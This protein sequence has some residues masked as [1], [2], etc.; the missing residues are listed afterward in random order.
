[1]SS[2]LPSCQNLQAN[3]ETLLELLNQQVSLRGYDTT[4]IQASLRKAISPSFEVVFAGAF[5]AGKSMLINA[6]LERELLY[7]A[8]GHATGTECYITYA[9][10]GNEQVVLTFLSEQEIQEQAKAL[11]NRLGIETTA[12]TRPEVMEMLTHKCQE[13]IDREGGKDKSER[14][15]DANALKLL[16]E[17]FQANKER[18]HPT[19][20]R[21][22]S[23]QQFNITNLEEAARYARRGNNSAVL[24]KIHYYCNH[25]LLQ[26]GN[27]L[28]DTPGIDAPVEKDAELTF[29]KVQHPDTS[30]VVCVMKTASA[31]DPTKEETRLMQLTRDNPGVRDRLFYVFNRVDE[32]WYNAQL[33]QRLEQFINNDFRN[34]DRSRL[35]KASGLLGFYG[36]Q[37]QNTSLETRFGL[38]TVFAE[39]I[40]GLGGQEE[41]PQFVNAFLNYCLTS[42][43]LDPIKFPLPPEIL[44][45]RTN[46]EKYVRIL[47]SLGPAIID[48]LLLDSGINEFRQSITQ[49]LTTEKR[50]Q[51]FAN[52]ADD[53]QPLCIALRRVY[54]QAWQ[55][56]ESQ[57]QDIEAIKEQ[58]LKQLNLELKRV[59]D[60]LQQHIE[61]LVNE[62]VAS[63]RNT[64]LER[65]FLKLKASL[66]SEMDSLLNT[67]S[68]A[69]VYKR[70]QASHKRNS[71]VPLLAVLAEAFYYLANGL[72]DVLVA[73]AQD[74]I[75]NFFTYVIEQVQQQDYYRNLYRLLGNDAGIEQTLNRLRNEA[76]AAII[77]E[78]QTE[79][80][81]YVRE[82][83]EFYT[84]GTVS[85]WQLRSTLQQACRGYDYQNMIDAEP[86][87]RQL[88]R[89][90]FEQKVKETVMRTFRQTI[91]QTI[92][93]PLL[94]GAVELADTILKQYDQA[95]AYLAR[96]LDREA[97]D[98]IRTYQARKQELQAS[99]DQFNQAV[100]GINAC[101]E[102]MNLDRKRLPLIAEADLVIVPPEPVPSLE[103][104]VIAEPTPT[105]DSTASQPEVLPD[106]G[107]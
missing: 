15:K 5:S 64:L 81:R 106:R 107:S 44:T 8:E 89:L 1:M 63:D 95:R 57:P 12:A 23:M 40:K 75:S 28:V 72:E 74:V 45:D 14:A 60:Q 38:D 29:T 83:P 3:V 37:I 67:F 32:T 62:A 80:D 73:T 56:V 79:C 25:P 77:N 7:S 96:T 11:C 9:E 93:T 34:T 53:V 85:I 92:N 33:R 51:L 24:R 102:A 52:L 59:G 101:L 49:Y 27:V 48:Q 97:Q 21:T 70:A 16:L 19:E 58:E 82:R 22:F 54:I 46:N 104:E 55:E 35:F 47:R 88:L 65:D 31:G 84:E 18:I 61:A 68:V 98:R 10:P 103:T 105:S 100:K 2:L 36:S 4:A 17:G 69:E 76:I 71:V 99:I 26:D 41:T 87:I 13:I 91:N 6:L 42:Q 78:A 50:P 66:V 90:D 30:A 20:N 43:K 39:S 86:A 94:E